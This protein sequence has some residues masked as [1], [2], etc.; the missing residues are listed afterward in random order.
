MKTLLVDDDPTMRK[1]IG[2]V[3]AERG[4]DVAATTDAEAALAACAAE[5]F[6]LVVVDSGPP[7]MDGIELCRRL[8]ASPGGDRRVVLVVTAQDHPDTLSKVLEAGASDYLAKPFHLTTLDARLALAERQVAN[9]EEHRRIEDALR[10]NE[11]HYRTLVEIAPDVIYGISADDGTFTSISPSFERT[12]GWAVDD[13]LGKP[14]GELVHVDDRA[15]ERERFAQT[16]RGDSPAPYELRIRTRDGRHLVAEFRCAPKIEAG[17]VVGAMGIARDITDRKRIEQMLEHRALHDSLTDLPNRALLHDRLEQAIHSAE[18]SQVGFA[19]AVMDLDHFKQVNDRFGHHAG[20]ML[21][22]AVADR[23]S[24]VLRASDTVARLGGD[25]F[26]I[27]MQSAV[28]E[29]DAIAVARKLLRVTQASSI[30]DGHAL[31]VAA[32]MGLALYPLH[33][34]DADSLLR[35]A[36]T[37]MYAAKRDHSGVAVCATG[38]GVQALAR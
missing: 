35:G 31:N 15:I 34:G 25:E 37:A 22:K 14:F 23:L 17:R 2:H 36:D 13:W 10:Q 18:R 30:V 32:S 11:E 38:R 9:L 5:P 21:L 12:T 28:G 8:R 7:R 3:L 29:R 19:F 24:S 1:L 33:G 4:H 20:D 26:A 16:V 6:P 27:I